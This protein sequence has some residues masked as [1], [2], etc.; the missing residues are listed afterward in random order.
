MSKTPTSPIPSAGAMR[1]VW[2]RGGA[3]RAGWL[4]VGL[5][6]WVVRWFLPYTFERLADHD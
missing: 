5:A 1:C 3:R 4:L 2:G 6:D